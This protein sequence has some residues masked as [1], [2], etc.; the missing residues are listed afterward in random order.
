MDKVKENIV[1]SIKLEV[2][3]E[4][5]HDISKGRGSIGDAVDMAL[6]KELT[7]EDDKIRTIT[8]YMDQE[9]QWEL[10]YSQC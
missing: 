3:K 7:D 5:W 8:I 1:G 4:T 6:S 2:I 9:A 10:S